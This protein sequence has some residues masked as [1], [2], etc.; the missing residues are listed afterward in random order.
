MGRRGEQRLDR[1]RRHFVVQ[2]H[3]HAEGGFAAQGHPHDLA[4]RDGIAQVCRHGVAE[5]AVAARPRARD[6]D[7]GNGGGGIQDREGVV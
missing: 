3:D 6:G 5:Q 7:I 4:D 1:E 2:A